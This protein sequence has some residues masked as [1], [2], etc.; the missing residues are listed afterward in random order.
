MTIA[1]GIEVRGAETGRHAEV[2][3]PEALA[4]VTSLQRQFN[5]TRVAL[6]AKRAE[7]QVRLDAGERP[8]FL[9][10]TQ[11]VREGDWRVAPAPKDLQDRR[12]EITGPVDRKMMINAFNSGARVF[13]AD[14]EDAN[15]PTWENVVEG[16]ANL[17]DA[18]NRTI[19]FPN[20]DG[21]LYRLNEQIATLL[22]RPRGWHLPE[23]HVLVD[24]VPI[25]ASLFDFGVYVF[26]NARRLLERGSGPYFY[27]PK[28]ESHLEARLWND[29]FDW[30][31]KELDLG[32]GKIKAT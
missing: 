12:V 14:F 2:L 22:A 28:L 24:G 13:M 3:T 10:E 26:H 32:H 18:I 6:L 5:P 21:R 15:S 9:P 27:L 11:Q 16:Q 1:P 31:E 19:E 17:I 25:S 30:T 7:R 20:P 4:F 23:R 29:I 8:D